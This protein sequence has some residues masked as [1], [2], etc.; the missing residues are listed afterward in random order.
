[1]SSEDSETREQKKRDAERERRLRQLNLEASRVE[2]FDPLPNPAQ[3][4]NSKPQSA[5]PTPHSPQSHPKT[6]EQAEQAEHPS[7][8]L[9]PSDLKKSQDE[10]KALIPSRRMRSSHLPPTT[11]SSPNKKY[12]M[13]D[14]P[15]NSGDSDSE[16]PGEDGRIV[17]RR[18]VDFDDDE[19]YYKAQVGE[20]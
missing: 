6:Q 8:T 15:E 18:D 4:P 10:T 9:N 11:P 19:H 17:V 5:N 12:D 14:E 7:P 20:I 3:N 1:M 2:N 16:D 13:F